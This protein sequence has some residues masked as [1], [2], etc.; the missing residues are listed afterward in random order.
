VTITGR[1]YEWTTRYVLG[2]KRCSLSKVLV[3][4]YCKRTRLSL[5]SDDIIHVLS[6]PDLG[7]KVEA[8]PG[9]LKTI[10][11]EGAAPGRYSSTPSTISGSGARDMTINV[12]VKAADAYAAWERETLTGQTCENSP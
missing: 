9:R 6:V 2:S 7:V 11:I 3:L 8:V 4:P 12:E 1:Q 10:V 5:T